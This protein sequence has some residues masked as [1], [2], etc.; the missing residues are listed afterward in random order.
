MEMVNRN[1]GGPA[2]NKIEDDIKLVEDH[3]CYLSTHE[4]CDFDNATQRIIGQY[5]K[6]ETACRKYIAVQCHWSPE[7]KEIFR[8]ICDGEPEAKPEPMTEREALC[9]LINIVKSGDDPVTSKI[10]C[11]KLQ[12]RL[13]AD[14]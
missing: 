11:E 13:E 12:E 14:K 3:Y 7:W 8:S 4:I 10:R 9:E 5:K 6:L 2:M 1:I